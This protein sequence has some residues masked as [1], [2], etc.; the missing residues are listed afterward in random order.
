M[1]VKQVKKQ[2]KEIHEAIF[3]NRILLKAQGGG[4]CQP[5]GIRKYV[6]DLKREPNAD[7]GP[8][9]IFETASYKTHN[10]RGAGLFIDQITIW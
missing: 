2:F 4:E 7:I 1:L 9:D 3:K 6:E 10:K 5:A 8:T